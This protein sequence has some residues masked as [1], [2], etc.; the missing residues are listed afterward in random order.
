MCLARP[1]NRNQD[2]LYYHRQ[3]IHAQERDE[4]RYTID[5]LIDALRD[6][7][8]GLIETEPRHAA[9]RRLKIGLSPTCRSFGESPST[10]SQS[11]PTYTR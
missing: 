8:D 1:D 6:I 5:V 10:V 9:S 4:F 11:E 3:S 2:P 7:L